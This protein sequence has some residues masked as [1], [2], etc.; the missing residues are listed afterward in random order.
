MYVFNTIWEFLINIGEA[1][2]FF[3]FIQ[4]KLEKKEINHIQRKQFCFLCF[5]VSI[6]FL[7][8]L[9]EASTLITVI[10]FLLLSMLFS[11]LF[12]QDS[13]ILQFFWDC[14]YSVLCLISEYITVAVSA[15][16]IPTD[17]TYL[18]TGGKL[19]IPFSLIYLCLI[20]VMVVFII[21]I[22]NKNIFLSFPQR[23]AFF[24]I[25]GF[26]I[27]TAHYIIVITL[28][29][30]EGIDSRNLTNSLIL[31]N[32]FFI[33][34]FLSSLIY[35]YRL[36]QSKEQN[37]RLLEQSKQYALEEQQYQTLLAST[38]TLREMKHDM[39]NHLTTIRQLCEI[40]NIEE[41]KNYV[42]SYLYTLD[43]THHLIS[44]GNSAI[45]CILSTKLEY[46]RQK[47]IE[48]QYSV[49]IPEPFPLDAISLSSL[50]GNLIDNALDACIYGIAASKDFIP[51]ISIYIKPF[52]G[53]VQIHIENNYLGEII[54]DSN[55]NIR[56]SKEEIN[57]GFGLKRIHAI[58]S[59]ANGM[60]NLQT[61]QNVFSVHIMIP[62]DE[63][64]DHEN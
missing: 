60:L 3:L 32:L 25:T 64:F 12:Y 21:D 44:T 34:M 1:V 8:N 57:H 11:A 52:Q 20:T 27:I 40:E 50:L 37:I 31:V 7:L 23:M 28:K 9:L 4:A 13:Y 63:E 53:M 48:F 35:I 5:Q 62:L 18:L 14:T 24:S 6:I 61:N 16:F 15:A 30:S 54:R 56:T 2:L 55:D 42:Q 17:V 43:N 29:S 58:V 33:V 36:G 51:W 19:R 45:D 22:E 10:S 39:Q 38:E 47:N 46:A 41:L 59:G 26:G 49:M